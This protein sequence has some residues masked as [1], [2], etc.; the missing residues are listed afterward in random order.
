MTANTRWYLSEVDTDFLR[1]QMNE[2]LAMGA[3]MDA[4]NG[5]TKLMSKDERAHD[6]LVRGQGGVRQGH[7]KRLGAALPPRPYRA[8]Q[9]GSSR[10][11]S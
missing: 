10:T 8:G 1:E 6:G 7:Q 2:M 4:M 5:S 3:T 9:C 11:S